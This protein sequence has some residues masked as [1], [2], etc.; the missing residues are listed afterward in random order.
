M[1]VIGLVIFLLDS[2]GVCIGA[3][4]RLR[5][6]LR[7]SGTIGGIQGELAAVKLSRS[8][9]TI[10]RGHSRATAGFERR[11]PFHHLP[12]DEFNGA[13][14]AESGGAWRCR[15]IRCKGGPSGACYAELEH[16]ADGSP[17]PQEEAADILR[18][19]ARRCALLHGIYE[20]LAEGGDV[21]SAA[22]LGASQAAAEYAKCRRGGWS[23]RFLACGTARPLTRE[24]QLA[25]I[26][27][28][29]AAICAALPPEERKGGGQSGGSLPL[30]AVHV[31]E[32][33]TAWLLR[34]LSSGGAV[35]GAA[36]FVPPEAEPPRVAR[37]GF[38]AQ[39]ALSKRP[40][41]GRTDMCPEVAFIAAN[42][43]SVRVNDSVWD[44]CAGACGLL[45]AAAALGAQVGGSD[46]DLEAV[47]AAGAN[48]AALGLPAPALA[49]HHGS[50]LDE[51]TWPAALVRRRPLD[52]VLC[53]PPYGMKA[54]VCAAGVSSTV[55][56]VA[57]LA[58]RRLRPG[59]RAALF[60]PSRRGG[61]GAELPA[62]ELP[63]ELGLVCSHPQVFDAGFVR[64]LYVLERKEVS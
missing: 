40:W 43:A 30:L 32:S 16:S 56:A 60:A 44:P 7:L 39:Y 4:H 29:E 41:R 21:A 59:G 35:G 24:E 46:V 54:A 45:I 15:F 10:F 63:R 23:L 27:P 52:A 3:L 13:L 53:D 18:Q 37:G 19:V 17:I 55:D 47:N 20:I 1:F 5:Q 12:V 48:F 34:R 31:P 57:R 61:D 38:L 6:H 49:L 58:A 36:D 33:S 22:A 42:L 2:R 26:E 8:L 51:A 62:P 64:T 28:A 11:R 14:S 50:V 25:R 9:L